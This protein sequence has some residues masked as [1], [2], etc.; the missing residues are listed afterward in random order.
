METAT[1]E[2]IQKLYKDHYKWKFD[3]LYFILKYN[4]SIY[5][6]FLITSIPKGPCLFQTLDIVIHY[7]YDMFEMNIV[8]WAI[9]D[10]YDFI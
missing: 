3:L 5:T 4:I 6:P 8:S 10:L 9:H 7:N 2:S 1:Y